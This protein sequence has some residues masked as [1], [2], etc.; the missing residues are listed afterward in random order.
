MATRRNSAIKTEKIHQ[1]PVRTI[2]LTADNMLAEF[3]ANREAVKK[4]KLSPARAA[5][6]AA[7][8]RNI[9]AVLGHKLR[10]GSTHKQPRARLV[11]A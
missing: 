2:E 5:G 1:L 4:G 3:W 7:F 9:T 10:H 11:V 6:M 8:D